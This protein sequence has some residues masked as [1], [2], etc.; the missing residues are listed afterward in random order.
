[1]PLQASG[2]AGP[3]IGSNELDAIQIA[4]GYVEAQHEYALRP[5]Q[6]YEVNLRATYRQHSGHTGRPRLADT[7]RQ[8]GGTNR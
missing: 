5:R 8:L 3:R 1:M 7:Q 2:A 6:G 4:R